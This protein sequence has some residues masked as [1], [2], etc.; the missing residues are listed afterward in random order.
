[1]P[2]L[3]VLT[4]AEN[5]ANHSTEAVRLTRVSILMLVC[6]RPQFI[7]RAIR[8]VLTQDFQD[9]ELIV[10]QEGAH[11]EIEAIVGGWV[12]QDDRIRYFS[13]EKSGNLASGYNFGSDRARGEYIAILDDD[14]YWVL[15]D[16]LTRQVAFLDAHPEYVGC[17]G[18]VLVS[19]ETGKEL[20]RLFKPEHD[21][22]IRRLALVANPIVHST[23]VFRRCVGGQF[24]RYDAA[25]SGIQ[26]WDIWLSLG[27]LGKLHNFDELFTCYTLWKRGVSF[28]RQRDNAKSA[29]KIVWRHRK[30]YKWFGPAIILALLGFVYACLPAFVRNRSFFYLSCV[31]KML[32]ASRCALEIRN[33]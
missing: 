15:P 26:D 7:D 25:L 21:H 6:N 29:V 10:V 19:D 1:M 18:G 2:E 11:R 16:K 17:G 8:S 24:S 5:S 30:S 22:E 12:S 23:A 31:K 3:K 27:R 32:F 33:Q 4:G 9:W 14:D 28:E 13:R 20:M